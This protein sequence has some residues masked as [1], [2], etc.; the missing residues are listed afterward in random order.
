MKVL[1]TV[2]MIL[3]LNDPAEKEL[4]EKLKQDFQLKYYSCLGNNFVSF[5]LFGE[6]D[7][8]IDE[9]Y[10]LRKWNIKC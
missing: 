8:I 5:E 10:D 4:A 3:V 9:N 6:F 7:K 2:T 1:T